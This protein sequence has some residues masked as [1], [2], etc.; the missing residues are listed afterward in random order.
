MISAHSYSVRITAPDQ[1][2]LG[3]TVNVSATLY[4]GNTPDDGDS[5]RFTWTD[6]TGQRKVKRPI[7]GSY[8][9]KTKSAVNRPSAV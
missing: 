7:A 1:A 9:K 4:N 3:A 6:S 2:L 5:Y 8:G